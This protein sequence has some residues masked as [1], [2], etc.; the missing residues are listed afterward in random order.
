MKN[1]IIAICLLACSL[2]ACTKFLEEDPESFIAPQNFYKSAADAEAALNSAYDLLNNVGSDSR[3]FEILGDISAD[4]LFPLSNN[5]DRVQIDQF[6]HTPINGVLRE[7]WRTMFQ[8]ITRTNAVIE[9]VPNITMPDEQKKRILAE[10]HFLRGLYYFYLVRWF[11][12]LPLITKETNSLSEVEYPSRSSVEEVYKLIIQ[13]LTT[14]EAGLPN[15]L[16]NGHAT[17][18]AATG[19]L[20]KVYLTR[21][22]WALAAQKAKEVMDMGIYSLW[23]TYKQAFDIANE[24]G[25][26]SL[27]EIQFVSGGVGQGSGWVTYFARENGPIT[28][29]GFGSFQPTPEVIDTL[30]KVPGDTRFPVNLTLDPV[31]NKY[32]VNKYQDPDATT[33]PNADNNWIILRYADVLLMYAE[34]LNELSANNPEAYSA[35]NLV[36]RRAFGK[37]MAS[38][39]PQPHD[40]LPDLSQSDFRRAVYAERRF[41][42]PF[43]GHRWFD[44]VRTG[45]LESTM[46]AKGAV[47]VKPFHV[48]FPVPQDEIALNPQLEQN[49]GY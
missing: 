4:D 2:Q 44:L 30:Q 41:E 25:R 28:G 12:P 5:N 14:A 20:A 45:R 33:F 29:R 34:A 38:V 6:V 1:K 27:F 31:D 15:V 42:L 24:N 19:L 35:I 37:D 36:R 23:P 39:T 10:A 40:V 9:R 26:E 13:D 32:Y 22:E 47:N 8:G 16:G 3:N 21:Q 11:G 43:E 17:K 48:L 18:G 49:T 7:T 46:Q